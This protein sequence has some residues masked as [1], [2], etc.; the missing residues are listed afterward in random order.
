MSWLWDPIATVRVEFKLLPPEV[1]ID[2][3]EFW[4]QTMGQHSNNKHAKDNKKSIVNSHH[5]YRLTYP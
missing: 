1:A 5:E 2:H 4:D 3:L